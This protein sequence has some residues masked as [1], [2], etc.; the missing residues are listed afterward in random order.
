MTG[1]QT[2][3]LPISERLPISEIE[4]GGQR[5]LQPAYPVK[6]VVSAAGAGDVT[7]AAF[8]LAL[9]KGLDPET[10][11]KLAARAGARCVMSVDSYSNLIPLE[12]LLKEID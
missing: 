9:E 5:L 10:S 12:E 11:L 1:V 4:W 3:A 8:L 2:C 7:I 6:Q